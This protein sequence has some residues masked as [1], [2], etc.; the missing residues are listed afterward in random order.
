MHC[1]NVQGAKREGGTR[2]F[3]FAACMICCFLCSGA[4]VVGQNTPT[5]NNLSAS[6]LLRRAVDGELK[7]QADDH[8]HWMYQ[9]KET[10]AGKEEVKCVVE[11]RQGALDRLLLVNGKPISAEQQKQEDRRIASLL[12]KPDVARKRQRAQQKDARE[13]EDLFRMLPNALTVKYGERKGDLVELLFEPNPK[14]APPTR[15]ASVF[16]SMEGRIWINVT[17][18]RLAEIEGHLVR[19]VKFGGGLLGYLD[20]G[21]EF[22]VRQSEVSPRYWEISLLHVNMHGKV[23]FF[24]TLSV[25][26]DESRSNFRQVPDNLTLAQAAEELQKQS[27]VKSAQSDRHDLPIAQTQPS[28]EMKQKSGGV[29]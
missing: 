19:D 1:P 27:G 22:H 25:Q 13:T 7:G 3:V 11:T 24:K 2:R 18:N 9:V 20:K 5:E 16:H 26:Q 12:N 4:A 6:E 29:L 21:G 14:F 8:T 10:H 15:E 23:L 28:S 17:E